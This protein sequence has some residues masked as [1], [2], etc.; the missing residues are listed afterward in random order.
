MP[1]KKQSKRNY[2]SFGIRQ[3]ESGTFQAGYRLPIDA[4][5][6]RRFKYFYAPS[7]EGAVAKAEEYKQAVEIGIKTEE[8][9]QPFLETS[10]L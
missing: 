10:Y 5:G 8:S 3:L 1:R 2:G 4:S 6:K 9:R 7:R